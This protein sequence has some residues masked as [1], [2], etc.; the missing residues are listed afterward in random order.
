MRSAVTTLREDLGLESAPTVRTEGAPIP[1]KPLKRW[2]DGKHVLLC[3]DAAGVVAPA[4]GEGIYYAMACGEVAAESVHEALAAHSAK[5]LR[6]ARSRFLRKHGRVFL[7]LGIM[8]RFWYGSDKRRERF[9][10]MCKDPDVQKL[11]WDS[12]LHKRIVW[13]DPMAHV[14]VFIKDVAHLLGLKRA[15]D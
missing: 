2:D 13:K 4:S 8:Q 7:V 3:G 9:V 6:R 5:P 12:Y 1:M 15:T 14:R 10:T 11:T